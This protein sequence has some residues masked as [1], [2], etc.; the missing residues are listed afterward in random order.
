MLQERTLFLIGG[1]D[2]ETAKLSAFR[3]DGLCH[4]QFR[5]RG[6][7]LEAASSDYFEAF[8]EIRVQL[9]KERLIPFCYGASLDVFPSGMGRNMGAGLKAYRLK[10]GK[11]AEQLVHIFDDGPDVIPSFV[12]KQKE[13]FQDWLKSLAR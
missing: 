2:D 4:I 9:E 8:S 6:N 3:K 1:E 5:Y 7:L 10:V 12:A 11:Q 13:F